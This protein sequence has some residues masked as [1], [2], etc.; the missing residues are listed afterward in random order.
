[1]RD[2]GEGKRYSKYGST[3]PLSSLPLR[4]LVASHPRL[5]AN[6]SKR[7]LLP[8]SE[9]IEEPK[10]DP[11]PFVFLLHSS[12]FFFLPQR[13][14][15]RITVWSV[16]VVL[17]PSAVCNLPKHRRLPLHS[18]ILPLQQSWCSAVITQTVARNNCFWG[19]QSLLH[20]FTIRVRTGDDFCGWRTLVLKQVT[21]EEERGVLL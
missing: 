4:L 14:S 21:T 19:R 16:G 20:A 17:F 5:C 10:K 6:G 13:S 12:S 18:I 11:A 1:M 3:L 7:S 15:S 2:G 9:L 8:H